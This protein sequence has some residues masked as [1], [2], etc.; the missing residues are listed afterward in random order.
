MKKCK[1]CEEE[2]SLS[3]YYKL[4]SGYIHPFCRECVRIYNREYNEKNAEILKE[5]KRQYYVENSET[6][7]AKTKSYKRMKLDTDEEYRFTHNLRRLI[8]YGLTT[9]STKGKTKSCA[10]YD[11]D[12]KGIYDKI[13]PK[14]GKD[15]QLEHTIPMSRFTFDTPEQ[16]KLCNSP[17]NLSWMKDKEN[18]TKSDSIPYEKIYCSLKLQ[19]IAK[20][21]GVI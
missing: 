3:E 9:Y 5:K 19:V 11:I 4:S 6:I 18:A 13:G 15:Y 1:K 20:K 10:E 7:Y 16:V 12:F 17:E 21:I 2:K 14:P 8:R